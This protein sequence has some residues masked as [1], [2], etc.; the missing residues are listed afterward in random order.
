MEDSV[1][2]SAD[3]DAATPTTGPRGTGT[4]W[5]S[6]PDCAAHEMGSWHPESPGRLAA[7]DDRMIASGLSKL[8]E[9]RD[10]PLADDDDLLRAHGQ[11]HLDQLRD[12]AP[13]AGYAALDP[14][15]TMCAATLNAV[16]RAAGAAV[17]ATD[18]VIEGRVRNAFCSTRPPGHHA[19]RNQA[20]GFCFVNNIAVAALR[21]LDVHGLSR[22]AVVDFDVHHGNGTENILSGDERVLMVSFFQHPFYPYSGVERPAGNMINVPLAAY[23]DGAAVRK[24]V[25]SK[26]LPALEAIRPELNFIS[27]GRT[28]RQSGRADRCL[29]R[30]PSPSPINPQPRRSFGE[31][32]GPS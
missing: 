20:M 25:D 4:A 15:T 29:S 32:S 7:I 2:V 8:V 10:V 27:A 30:A 9:S 22:V 11:A 31:H 5:Y 19:T 13:E 1:L 16:L 17:A 21:A 28:R 18:A 12:C 14:D 23:S 3:A 6:H 24:V 26:W